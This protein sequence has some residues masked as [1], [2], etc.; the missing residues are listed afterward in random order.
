MNSVFFPIYENA[1][2]LKSSNSCQEW[3]GQS[4]IQLNNRKKFEIQMHSYFEQEA[5]NRLKL[6]KEILENELWTLIRIAPEKLPIGAL[7]IIPA[8]EFFGLRHHEIKSYDAIASLSEKE[9]LM[10]Y[11]IEYPELG[12]TLLIKFEKTFPF[13]IEAWEE[14]ISNNTGSQEIWLTTKAEKIKRIRNAYWKEN[15]VED[16]SLRDNLGL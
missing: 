2:A 5:D 9:Q 8:L 11:R 3:C 13:S 16:L 10:H 7:K 6:E 4:Y 15:K 14:S 1:H 12:R